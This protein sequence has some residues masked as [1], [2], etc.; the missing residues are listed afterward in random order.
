MRSRANQE[1]LL[2][3]MDEVERGQTQPHDLIEP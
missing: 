1:R 2:A 3:A